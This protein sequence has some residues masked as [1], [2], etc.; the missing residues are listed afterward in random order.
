MAHKT[1]TPTT[2]ITKTVHTTTTDDAATCKIQELQIRTPTEVGE[3]YGLSGEIVSFNSGG[4]EIPGSRMTFGLQDEDGDTPIKDMYEGATAGGG[5]TV[6]DALE[7]AVF[8]MLKVEVNPSTGSPWLP[9][10]TVS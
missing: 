5:E 6:Q 9:A 4:S 10:G 2:P 3:H 1:F 7:E 8:N